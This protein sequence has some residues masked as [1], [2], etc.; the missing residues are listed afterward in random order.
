[1]KR[2]FCLILALMMILPVLVACNSNG[3]GNDTTAPSTTE[4]PGITETPGTTEIPGTTETPGTSAAPVTTTPPADTT[5]P[6]NKYELRTFKIKENLDS[7]KVIGRSSPSKSVVTMD[8]SGSGIEFNADFE[9]FLEAKMYTTVDCN[10]AVYIDGVA[11]QECMKIREGTNT[12]TLA[13]GIAAGVHNVRIIK[14]HAAEVGRPLLTSINTV[15][16]KGVLDEKPADKKYLVEFIGD[17]ITC[18]YGA[19]SKDDS[20]TYAHLT[21]AYLF[22]QKNDYD[23]SFVAVSGI[24]TI[25]SGERHGSLLMG[26]IYPYVSYYRDQTEKYEPERQADMVVIALNTNDNG[27]VTDADKNTYKNKVRSLLADVKRIHGDDVKIVW[28]YGMMGSGKCDNWMKEV[29]EELGGKN[30]GYYS[31][32]A[33]PDTSGASSHPSAAGHIENAERLDKYID[34]YKVL[35]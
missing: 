4:A 9:G 10:I 30:A 13:T 2:I 25:K 19:K 24:G 12:Y 34:T 5:P 18:G 32:Q 29:L 33:K 3:N 31:F 21:Y 7:I 6:E 14:L 22:C 28:Y 16:F 35:G 17:S 23:Y 1:M 26:D 8:W 15:T 27:R 11:V 20:T